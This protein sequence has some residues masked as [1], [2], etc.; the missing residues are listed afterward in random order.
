MPGPSARTGS[1]ARCL[2]PR[3]RRRSRGTAGRDCPPPSRRSR[4][5]DRAPRGT[6]RSRRARPSSADDGG[7]VLG[8]SSCGRGPA[9]GARD[10]VR[11][12]G[13]RRAERG[14][15]PRGCARAWRGRT[16]ARRNATSR[17]SSALRGPKSTWPPSDGTTVR[18]PTEGSSAAC[19][20]PVPAPISATGPARIRPAPRAA[21]PA[22]AAPRNRRPSALATKSLTSA[23]TGGSATRRARAR[24]SSRQGEVRDLRARRRAPG[25][26]RRIRP[27]RASAARPSREVVDDLLEARVLGARISLEPQD[28]AAPV[29]SRRSREPSWFRRCRPRESARAAKLPSG[30]RLSRNAA[31]RST[32]AC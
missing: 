16:G 14:R 30:R 27:P 22:A 32:R 2:R 11:P 10:S 29:R 24:S 12:R 1:S 26:R 15:C 4:R 23:H 19:P 20:R 6:S 21:W 13:T 31:D 17:S 25:P 3:R 9:L 18:P 5:R 28:A 8:A 7:P